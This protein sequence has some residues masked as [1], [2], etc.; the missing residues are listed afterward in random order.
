MSNPLIHR[1]IIELKE[2]QVQEIRDSIKEADIGDFATDDALKK[3]FSKWGINA[4]YVDQQGPEES[5]L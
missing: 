3:A 4:D 1:S 5:G 2:W